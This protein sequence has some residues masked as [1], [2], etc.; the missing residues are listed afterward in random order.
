M[1]L[2]ARVDRIETRLDKMDERLRSV[3]I[4]VGEIKGKIDG[5]AGQVGQLERLVVS[6]LPSWWQIPAIIG[7][8]ITL[9]AIL[10]GGLLWAGKH[11]V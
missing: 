3:E 1:D 2:V 8:T 11:L 5:L 9:V 4:G 6:K 10:G 7:A